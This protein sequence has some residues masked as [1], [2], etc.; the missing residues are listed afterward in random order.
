MKLLTVTETAQLLR[1][2]PQAVYRRARRGDLPVLRLGR[3]LRI[4]EQQLAEW[5]AAHARNGDA[6]TT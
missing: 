6:Q 5:L 3:Q 4:D 2:T 1:L